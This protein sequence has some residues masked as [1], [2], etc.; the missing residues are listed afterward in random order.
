MREVSEPAMNARTQSRASAM[1]I[2]AAGRVVAQQA[3]IAQIGQSALGETSIEAL[4]AE[5]CSVAGRIL[6]AEF[7]SVLEV[8]PDGRGLKVVAGTGWR[9]G[10]VGELVVG[11]ANDSQSGYT[12]ATGGPVISDDLSSE[13]RFR[14]SAAVMEHGAVSGMSVRVG[15]KDKPIGVLAVFS[16]RSGRYSR[17]DAN[18]LQSI[19]NVLAAAVVRLRAEAEM[20]AS[21]DE[22]AAIVSTIDEG[23][24]VRDRERLIFANDAAAQVTGYASAEEFL[25]AQS[26]VL[27]RYDIFDEEGNPMAVEALPGRRAMAGED[28]PEAVVGFR[29]HATGELRWSLV[30][31]TAVRD[32]KGEVTHVIN[33]FREITDERWTRESRAF[34]AEAVA[35]LSST[36]D[37]DEA[38]RRLAN[39]AVPRL[40]D[41]CTVHMLA[42]DGSI[43]NVALAHADA[44][45]LD[46]AVRIQQMRPVDPNASTG[47]ARVIREGTPEILEVT[48]AMIDAAA[49]TLSAEELDLVK[50]LEMRWYLAVPLIGRQGPIG[51]L[52]LVMA[53]S[54]RIL[55]PRDMALAEELGARAGIALE[56]ARLYQASNDRRAQLDAVLGALA[57]AVLVFDFDGSLQLSNNAASA[58]F[59]GRLPQDLGEFHDRIGLGKADHQHDD[60]AAADEL[61]LQIDGGPGWIEI[62]RYTTSTSAAEP[63]NARAPTVMVLRDVTQARA[64]R[65]ARDAFLGVLSHELR[66]PITTIYGGSELLER[67][68]APERRD[69][70]IGDI[71]V[72]AERLARL[73]E[74]LLV[75]TRIERGSVEISDEPILVQR[76]LPSV[77]RAFNGQ[78]PDVNVTLYLSERL[79]AVRGDPTYV[80]QVVRNL[81][82][83]AVRYGRGTETGITITVEEPRGEVI[84]RV[85]DDGPGLGDSDPERLFELFYRSDAARS[86]P[87]G[88]G[89][90][91]FVCRNLIE[92]MGGRIWAKTRDE[93]GAEFG[94]TLPVVESDI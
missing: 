71:R 36:L 26:G 85:Q 30:R 38:A 14:A 77:V 56:N 82:T 32:A 16:G 4:Y 12:I 27:G 94:F 78:W 37:T 86:V 55:G 3:A 73:V 69:E 47:I 1:G 49:A 52:A 84:V 20:R 59:G 68:L 28:K 72:E 64:T 40:A 62:R 6:E 17:D 48:P 61:E 74:D 88:A 5:A 53:E 8:A 67:G 89:I 7:V 24:T 35:V 63:T 25:T 83:N 66:T 34:M 13:Q 91:L 15:E 45:R 21:R 11:L 22:L 87:G 75:M 2:S 9:P 81:L 31:G 43:V 60:E 39:L 70:I 58:M 46:T 42:P 65:A 80:E 23:I 57:E 33:T 90:G 41:Y 18:F 76:L 10:I 19:A 79:S 29:I 54:G 93:G 92:A 44:E 51:A 50:R